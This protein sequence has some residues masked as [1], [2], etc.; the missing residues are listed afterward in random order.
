MSPGTLLFVASGGAI[1]AVLRYIISNCFD[2]NGQQFPWGTFIAN[3][4]G[5]FLIGILYIVLIE[6]PV[7]GITLS[8]P[9]RHLLMVGF[10]GALTTYSSFSL[11]SIQLITNGYYQIAAAYIVS[12]LITCLGL[13]ML[14]ILLTR[15]ILSH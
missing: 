2:N 14:G 5:A 1:G 7:W 6:K 11:E 13:T 3:T 9:L 8:A 4:S 15:L 10:L 12:T